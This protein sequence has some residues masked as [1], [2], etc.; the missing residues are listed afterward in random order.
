[1]TKE[2]KLVLAV[3]VQLVIIFA[4]IIFKMSILTG[5]TEIMLR[6]EPVDP[7]DMLR[8]DY[9]TFRYSNLSVVPGYTPGANV[10]G[11]GDSI[12]VVLDKTSQGYYRVLRLQKEMPTKDSIFIKGVV[13]SGGGG[14]IG[15][16]GPLSNS[17]NK[18]GEVRIT[19]GIEQY[20]IPEG[21]GVGFSFNGKEAAAAVM[22]DDSGNATLKQIYIDKKPWP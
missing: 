16:V 11:S 1:M 18:Y 10:V 15:D 5:G 20:F 21:K 22:I 17:R 6:I 4:I 13:E 8:G 2:I 14:E 19:Y 3:A 12:F 9:A 7:R